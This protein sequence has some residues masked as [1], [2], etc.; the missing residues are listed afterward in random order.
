MNIFLFEIKAQ[1]KTFFIWT[2][3]L[4]FTY[5]VFFKGIYPVFYDSLDDVLQMMNGFP[6]E[7]AAAFGINIADM[8]SYSGFFSFGFM[9]ISII[10]AIMAVILTVSAFARE[11]RSK[12]ADFLLT[13]PIS[14]RDIFTAKLI[15]NLVLLILSNIIFVAAAVMIYLSDNSDGALT[16]QFILAASGIF[17]TQLIFLSIGIFYAVFSKRVR[18][19]AGAATAFGF[20][21]FILSALVNI[22]EEEALFF[23]APLQY[24]EPSSVFSAGT[25][26]SKYVITAAVIIAL[27]TCLAYLKFCRSDA[28]VV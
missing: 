5:I 8:F 25:Y 10:G 9:Y 6:P 21:S 12:C 18:S 13:K 19:I 3:V 17:F 7:F 16:V 27:L 28:H 11:K 24:F 14:R 23:I 15:S 2:A 22:L 20:G 4:L 1:I 26:E